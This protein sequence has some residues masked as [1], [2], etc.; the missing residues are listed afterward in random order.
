MSYRQAVGHCITTTTTVRCTEWRMVCTC[1]YHSVGVMYMCSHVA[2]IRKR[3]QQLAQ[4]YYQTATFTLRRSCCCCC[5]KKNSLCSAQ[6][7][8]S[9]VYTELATTIYLEYKLLSF[10]FNSR[11]S[12]CSIR[13]HTIQ[14]S[15]VNIFRLYS[16]HG[17]ASYCVMLRAEGVIQKTPKK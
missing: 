10:C 9:Q 6:P 13:S 3:L 1:A 2:I 5:S 12:C 15:Q 7:Q 16:R 4:L 17:L 14:V 8:D 11:N